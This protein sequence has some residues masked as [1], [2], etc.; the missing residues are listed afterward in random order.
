MAE[1]FGG[2]GVKAAAADG[3]GQG[4]APKANV[5][6]PAQLSFRVAAAF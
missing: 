1:A 6:P 5:L 2:G 4:I 3:Q